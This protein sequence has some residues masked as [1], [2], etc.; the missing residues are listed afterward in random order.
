MWT[1]ILVVTMLSPHQGQ[2]ML[3]SEQK[4][5]TEQ[6]CLAQVVHL[7]PQTPEL[8]HK[9]FGEGSKFEDDAEW[10]CRQLGNPA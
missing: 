8:L 10:Q 5:S 9:L 2:V 3:S 4:M 6:D 1:L 7:K